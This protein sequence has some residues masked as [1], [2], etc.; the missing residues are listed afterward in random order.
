[1]L[2]NASEGPGQAVR[3]CTNLSRRTLLALQD[4]SLSGGS[5][6]LMGAFVTLAP[7]RHSSGPSA[8]FL[9]CCSLF[10]FDTKG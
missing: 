1:M 3:T 6:L 9:D 4:L 2:W 7:A 5:V 8:H 10:S